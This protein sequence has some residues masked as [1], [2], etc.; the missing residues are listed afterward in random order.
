MFETHIQIQPSFYLL[1]GR[2][3]TSAF[4]QSICAVPATVSVFL[5]G[6]E[7]A[8]APVLESRWT[9]NWLEGPEVGAVLDRKW[10]YL[11]RVERREYIMK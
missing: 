10:S 11:W 5:K 2:G 4:G 6:R 9:L 7:M 3:V 1:L 8:P